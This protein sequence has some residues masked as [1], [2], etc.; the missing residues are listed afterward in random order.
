MKPI[1][2]IVI[3]ITCSLYSACSSSRPKDDAA[4]TTAVKAKLAVVFG[5]LEAR[6]ERQIDR[7]ANQQ[8]VSHISVSSLNGV[9]TLTGEVGSKRAKIRA[10]ET[11]RSVPQ[12][13]SVTNNLSIAPGYSDDALGDGK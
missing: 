10:A 5:P 2:R 11:A 12:V 13:A 9:V 4:I 1:L 7:G 8:T 3:V 6:Q